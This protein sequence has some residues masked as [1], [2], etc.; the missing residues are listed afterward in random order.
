MSQL[1]HW[2]TR[3]PSRS[4]STGWRATSSSSTTR[5]CGGR[6]PRGWSF[7]TWTSSSALDAKESSGCFEHGYRF[8][9][10]AGIS[11]GRDATGELEDWTADQGASS[12]ESI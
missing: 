11:A 4:T 12:R 9:G 3:A 5:S 2:T 7:L 10:E 6:E 1:E 8:G